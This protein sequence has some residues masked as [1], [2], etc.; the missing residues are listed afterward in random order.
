MPGRLQ[1]M[2]ETA[3]EIARRVAEED[4]QRARRRTLAI[5]DVAKAAKAADATKRRC[6]ERIA[7]LRRRHRE[8]VA[9]MRGQLGVDVAAER[10]REQSA[11]SGLARAVVSALEVFDEVELA[12]YSG[13]SDQMVAALVRSARAA[14]S[15]DSP[16]KAEHDAHDVSAVVTDPDEG[17][18]RKSG[19][20]VWGEPVGDRVAGPYR[21]AEDPG[22]A[23]E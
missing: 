15:G 5:R 23:G 18:M 1:G 20:G 2:S 12:R 22:A 4:R 8:R 11:R 7:V 19:R 21:G 17:V 9:V 13:M 10:V 3:R 6:E 16:G 14:S